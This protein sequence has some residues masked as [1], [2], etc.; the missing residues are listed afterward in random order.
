MKASLF[1]V[2]CFFLFLSLFIIIGN[3]LK[4]AIKGVFRLDK[5]IMKVSSISF[6]LYIV[7]F[8]LYLF[9]NS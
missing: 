2:A 1:V 6:I 5:K 3:L 9:L 8:V 7:C 4:N